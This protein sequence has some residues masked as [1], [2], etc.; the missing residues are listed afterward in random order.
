[1]SKEQFLKEN[2]K[3]G[4]IY[5]G[6][7]L[8]DMDYHLIVAPYRN[9]CKSD[10]TKLNWQESLEFA[11]IN[12]VLL[13]TISDLTLISINTKGVLE[14]GTYWSTE[15]FILTSSWVFKYDSGFNVSRKSVCTNKLTNET[16]FIRKIYV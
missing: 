9:V 7:I 10:G 12:N 8:S 13:P 2:L 16:L 15:S 1:M 5:A 11:R 3:M 14:S 4:E 6:L